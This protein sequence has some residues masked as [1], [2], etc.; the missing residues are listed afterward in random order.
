MKTLMLEFY[1]IKRRKV[2]LT[3]AAF[4]AAQ[5]L[6]GLWALRSPTAG[7]QA[8]GFLSLLYALPALD[9][10]M[11]PPVM[12]ILET[13]DSSCRYIKQPRGDTPTWC[14]SHEHCS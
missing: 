8:Q 2:G 4:L 12:A 9:A 7:E 5:F 14:H 3:M 13:R 11:V 10:V 6:W 1:K